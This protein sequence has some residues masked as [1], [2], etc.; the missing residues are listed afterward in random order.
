MSEQQQV[1][2]GPFDGELSAR[3]AQARGADQLPGP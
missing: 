3:V 2:L 1:G